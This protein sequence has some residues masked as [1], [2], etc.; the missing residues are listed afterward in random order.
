MDQNSCRG[1]GVSSTPHDR[2]ADVML[3]NAILNFSNSFFASPKRKFDLSSLT[4]FCD[5]C[6]ERRKAVATKSIYL[7]D[8]DLNSLQFLIFSADILRS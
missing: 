7:D 2:C 3:V 4:L 6:L 8:D 1:S 5:A